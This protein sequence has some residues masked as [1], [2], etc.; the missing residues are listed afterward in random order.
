MAVT[1][2]KLYILRA[3]EQGCSTLNMFV[4]RISRFDNKEFWCKMYKKQLHKMN[5]MREMAECFNYVVTFDFD[6]SQGYFAE[7]THI[8]ILFIDDDGEV[9]SAYRH[10]MR[11]ETK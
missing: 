3:L 8:N 4:H 10:D 11:R 9:L 1:G 6:D 7:V 2:N 5:G